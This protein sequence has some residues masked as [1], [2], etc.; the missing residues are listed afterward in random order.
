MR[1]NDKLVAEFEPQTLADI[2]LAVHLC[3]VEI[4]GLAKATRER[5]I[6]KVSGEALIFRQRCSLALTEPDTESL[7]QWFN[8]T[9][10]SGDRTKINEMGTYKLWW[11]SHVWGGIFFSSQD[12]LTMRNFVSGFDEWWLALVANK[13]N[14]WRLALVEKNEGF[15]K[16]EEMPFRVIPEINKK[17]FEELMRAREE[18]IKKI[19]EEKVEIDRNLRG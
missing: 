2:F 12:H 9:A 15:F 1:T 4:S 3:E 17:E 8:E 7:N 5:N 6:F 18:L 16:Y 10:S 13:K 11:H 14:H 19:V